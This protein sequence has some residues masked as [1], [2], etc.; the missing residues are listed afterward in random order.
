MDKLSDTINLNA[1]L[2]LKEKQKH[3]GIP[4]DKELNILAQ[5][6]GIHGFYVIN[7]DGKFLRSSDLPIAQQKNSLFSYCNG[8]REL[9]YGKATKKT[10]PI[11]PGYP[12]NV[13]DKFIMIPNYDKQLILE[14]GYYLKYMEQ[15]LHEIVSH[16]N[17]I[18]SIG[19][20]APNGYELGY[21]GA[22]A[23][24]IQG[25]TPNTNNSTHRHI[26]TDT[27]NEYLQDKNTAI[28][29]RYKVKTDI[30]YCCE[31]VV[32]KVANSQPGYYYD[33]VI[34]V[35]QKPL[36]NQINTLKNR[37]I[38]IIVASMLFSLILSR[39]I[40]KKIVSRLN[41]INK[42]VDYIMGSGDLERSLK[43]IKGNDEVSKLSRS[44]NKM[45]ES[46]KQAQ[47]ELIQTEKS[48]TLATLAAEV[49]HDIGSP[50]ATMGIAIHNLR[51]L[52]ID[53][54]HIDLLAGSMRSVKSIAD[55]LLN[56]Y[57][58]MDELLYQE[59]HCMPDDTKAPRYILLSSLITNIVENKKSEWSNMPC[60]I[61][62]DISSSSKLCFAL[63]S[64][65]E[66]SRA[67][68]N[69]LNNAYESLD[70]AERNILVSLS[71]ID[72]N[73][74][75]IIS[76]NGAGIPTNKIDEVLAGKSL[77]HSGKGLGLSSAKRYF[78]SIGAHLAIESIVTQ[79]T[80]I[81]VTMPAAKN[82][83]WFFTTITYTKNSVLAILDD[84][85][86]IIML[87]QQLLINE[88][89]IPYKFFIDVTEFKKW[90]SSELEENPKLNQNIVLLVDYDLHH[91]NITGIDIIEE[92]NIE[93]AYI[94][95]THAEIAWLQNQA[96]EKSLKLA[97]KT[98]IE[99]I[100]FRLV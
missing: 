59:E 12:N 100:N 78:E 86:S 1:V 70:K 81:K 62:L 88:L 84:D 10:T 11:I 2:I 85:P 94:F 69:L 28:T 90:Y 61:S 68:S 34:Q 82:P 13:P 54:Q 74:S 15:T 83:A 48:K 95:S 58:N 40:S 51:K 21:I 80:T 43:G 97:P 91:N 39:I 89:G 24:F 64:P 36:I 76:D 75:L 55:N 45:I 41:Y 27:K 52:N 99:H 79:G 46:L 19:L 67:L 96:L 56:R 66:L 8:Y 60:N 35:S 71:T 4:S 33:L 87:W 37:I 63:I 23:K 31:C 42:E 38:I 18:M 92:F 49:A 57:R 20:Y 30:D 14:A 5:K 73:F 47:I 98:L 65:L 93:H 25:T 72:N 22:D 50:I 3:Q 26:D 6:L 16:D 17:N 77:K 44:F 9:V 53:N 7:K 32:K 29:L